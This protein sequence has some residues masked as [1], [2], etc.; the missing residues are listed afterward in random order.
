MKNRKGISK[1]ECV[2]PL[3]LTYKLRGKPTVYMKRSLPLVTQGMGTMLME[4]RDQGPREGMFREAKSSDYRTMIKTPAGLQAMAK[5]LM[6]TGILG[7]FRLA[8]LLLYSEG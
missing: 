1:S 2:D 5:Y 7:Q 6:N 3:G 8:N 4:G